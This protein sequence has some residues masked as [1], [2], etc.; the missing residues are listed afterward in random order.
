ML[1]VHGWLDNANS[2]VPIMPYLPAFDL[3]AVDLPGHGYSDSLPGGYSP[4]E[5]VYQMCRV[6]K[7]LQWDQYHFMGHSLGAC[8]A[9]LL[10]T[11]QPDTVQSLT[12]IEGI[13]PLSED[14]TKLPERIHRS[15]HDRLNQQR[16]ASR[17]FTNKD[18]AVAARQK[19]ATMN[20]ASARLII[21]RQLCKTDSGFQW[22]FDPRW[23]LASPQYLTEEQVLAILSTVQ[24]PVLTILA[25]DGYLVGKSSTNHRLD[26]LANGQNI[27]LT[28]HHHLH[29]DTPEPVAANINRFL[30]TKPDLGDYS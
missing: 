6:A 4:H 30:E 18:E 15:L 1:C 10:A 21:D 13:G 24:C 25:Q 12:L 29:M 11:A 26:R 17:N 20:Q 3:V 27:T 14:A 16:V 23:R 7:A 2:F 28:G 19:A 8:L 22:R 5:M 9:P